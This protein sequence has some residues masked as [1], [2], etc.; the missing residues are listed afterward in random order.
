MKT[1]L[2]FVPIPSSYKQAME[3][4]YWQ[5][6]IETELLALEEN[7]TWDTV[8][9]PPLIKPL[10]SKQAIRLIGRLFA[11]MYADMLAL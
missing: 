3:H 10:G 4:K 9:S 1:T 8:P 6:S 2:A 11:I 5:D 7:Q